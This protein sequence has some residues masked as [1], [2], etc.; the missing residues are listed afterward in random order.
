ML[1]AT[2]IAV[3]NT[4]LEAILIIVLIAMLVG[5]VPTRSNATCRA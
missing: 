3:F 4:M 1:E 2:L 5:Y